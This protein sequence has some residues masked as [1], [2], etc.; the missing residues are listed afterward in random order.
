V[1][2][3]LHRIV[4]PQ[5]LID[6]VIKI[7]GIGKYVNGT[8][9]AEHLPYENRTHRF[10]MIVHRHCN[11]NHLTVLFRRFFSWYDRSQSGTYEMFVVPHHSQLRDERWPRLI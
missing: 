9:T 1:I 5:S 2:L 3:K 11:Q 6:L 4:S 8:A 10:I 7:C